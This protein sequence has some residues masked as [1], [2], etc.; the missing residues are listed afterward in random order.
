MMSAV[1][2]SSSGAAAAARVTAPGATRASTK[3]SSSARAIRPIRNVRAAVAAEYP[4][5]SVGDGVYDSD[6]V[7][8]PLS[9]TQKDALLK[10]LRADLAW[11]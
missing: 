6:E 9:F 5:G 7:V 1:A 8:T 3:A 11:P 4:F 2:F 10:S